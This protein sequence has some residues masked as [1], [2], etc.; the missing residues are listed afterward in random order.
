MALFRLDGKVA[1][2]TGAGSGIGEQAALLFARQGATVA[3]ADVNAEG[4]QRVVEAITQDGGTASF[5]TVNVTDAASVQ[6][7][8]DAVTITYGRLDIGINNAG[9]GFVGDVLETTEE[10]YDRLM[11]VNVRG[12]FLCAQAEVRWMKEH[13]GGAIINTSSVAGLVG[14]DRRFAYSTTKGAVTA[15]TK[16]LAVDHVKDRIRVNC[17][18][19][20]TV[21]TP[22][23]D[24]YL[25]KHHAGEEEATRVQLRARQPL[26]RLGQPDEIAYAMLYLAS[27]EA[28]FVTGSALIID[29]GLTAR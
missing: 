22:F 5:Y 29:G 28:A 10:D 9:I 11:A 12:V 3:V 14:V 1:F 8:I 24:A 2:I 16:Q 19:P 21:E 17:V 15:M 13:G 20:G 23:V 18:C 26:G 4:G 25:R 7:G 6:A 27:D